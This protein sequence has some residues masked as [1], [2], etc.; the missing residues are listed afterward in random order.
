MCEKIKVPLSN[1]VLIDEMDIDESEEECDCKDECDCVDLI[2]CTGCD[3]DL[4]PD[5]V[6][7]WLEETDEVYCYCCY[8]NLIEMR[9]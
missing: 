2:F 7:L 6:Y 3:M 9:T 5:E 1:I 4:Q 8:K